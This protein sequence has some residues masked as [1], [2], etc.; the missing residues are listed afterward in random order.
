MGRKLTFGDTE[1]CTSQ[2]PTNRAP[3]SEQAHTTAHV[4]AV[5][6]NSSG[7]S[8]RL[9]GPPKYDHISPR[10]IPTPAIAPVKAANAIRKARS[11]VTQRIV[12]APLMSAMGRKQTMA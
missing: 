3:K 7:F 10:L 6:Q 11:V 2:A 9:T 12:V 5:N 4:T 1:D 8:A